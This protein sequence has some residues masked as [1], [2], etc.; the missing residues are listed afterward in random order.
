MEFYQLLEIIYINTIYT[1]DKINVI[2]DLD[3]MRIEI[4][5]GPS[6]VPL[7]YSHLSLGESMRDSFPLIK[8][9]I[10]R[11]WK[12]YTAIVSF[13]TV[14]RGLAERR[15]EKSFSRKRNWSRGGIQAET[16][17]NRRKKK[18]T[19]SEQTGAVVP[20]GILI[21]SRGSS[22]KV[23]KQN[24]SASRQVGPALSSA[25]SLPFFS[26]FLLLPLGFFPIP[27]R[28]SPA[29]DAGHAY[30]RVAFVRTELSG[31]GIKALFGESQSRSLPPSPPPHRAPGDYA[32]IF[33]ETAFLWRRGK[34]SCERPCRSRVDST[35]IIPRDK[36]D[37]RVLD[38]A[39]LYSF[40]LFFFLP[41]VS[42]IALTRL[43]F[44]GKYHIGLV[45]RGMKFLDPWIL[46]ACR[47]R[48][49]TFMGVEQIV[50][51]DCNRDVERG[52]DN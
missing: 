5:Q 21:G 33:R 10:P 49:D 15:E 46:R 6:F 8:G 41:S 28:A 45:V 4:S 22:E 36:L 1:I 40:L 20:D 24:K 34:Y 31:R 39:S 9:I 51:E 3:K 7:L 19:D 48:V 30:S 52:S 16:K 47:D 27:L 43:S 44:L 11:G 2:T 13:N 32:G 35:R 50:G 42:F 18:G 23:A 12:E 38:N 37:S 29:R 25:L 14:A 26:S 17:G